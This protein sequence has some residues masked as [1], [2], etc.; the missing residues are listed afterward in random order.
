MFISGNVMGATSPQN[1]TKSV[2]PGEEIDISVPMTAPSSVGSFRGNWMLRNASGTNFGVDGVSEFWVDIV[3]SG[4]SVTPGSGTVTA[5]A[6]GATPTPTITSTPGPMVT[7]VTIVV[8]FP[9]PTGPCPGTFTFNLSG[10]ITLSGPIQTG[11]E[12]TV[13]YYWNLNGT[14]SPQKFTLKFTAPGT[15]PVESYEW[16]TP[17]ISSDLTG[18]V[19]LVVESPNSKSASANVKATCQ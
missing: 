14:P 18:T 3:V 1:L 10:T 11:D 8:D 16:T 12:I 2:A 17:S 15:L 19:S 6:T 7:G 13:A 5:T 9:D 4:G